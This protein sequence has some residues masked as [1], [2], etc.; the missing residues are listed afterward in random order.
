MGRNL[1][2]QYALNTSVR[3]GRGIVK[4]DARGSFLSPNIPIAITCISTKEKIVELCTIGQNFPPVSNLGA[5]TFKNLK[6]EEIVKK[7]EIK[8]R[9]E[10]NIGV[11]I[12]GVR[13][14]YFKKNDEKE[15]QRSKL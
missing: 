4:L 2:R 14:R 11:L 13:H 10:L 1:F 5:Y 3:I 8:C 9:S 6:K 12:K 7:L 15:K